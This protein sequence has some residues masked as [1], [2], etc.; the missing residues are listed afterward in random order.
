MKGE[1]MQFMRRRV[2]VLALLLAAGL[3]VGPVAA[4]VITGEDDSLNYPNVDA[5]GNLDFSNGNRGVAKIFK[6]TRL[7]LITAIARSR[8]T[9]LTGRSQIY[10]N[11]GFPMLDPQTDEYIVGI[12]SVTVSA[13]RGK[14]RAAEQIL[15][16]S[17]L[18]QP[19]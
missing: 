7:R 13:D 1:N 15:A 9:N 8:V 16:A 6:F 5:A 19:R 10:F 18:N 2:A 14:Q 11:T 4:Q 12:D 3:L 17:S